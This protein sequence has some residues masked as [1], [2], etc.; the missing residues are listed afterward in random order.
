MAQT[1]F[2]NNKFTKE[3]N[4]INE[5]ASRRKVEELYRSFKSD[6]SSFTETKAK[7]RCDL[8]KLRE[9][10]K[11][12]F[13]S[14]AIEEDPVELIL[15]P[16]VIEKLQNVN[17]EIN[18]EPPTTNELVSTIKKLKCGKSS[19]DIPVEYIKHSLDSKKFVDEI[20]KLF[21]KF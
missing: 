12:H 19:N 7:K 11:K 4:E 2:S 10:F 13:T 8:M 21:E 20:T 9:H 3:A 16:D 6:N 15:I 1:K 17:L 14:T 18:S 5:F